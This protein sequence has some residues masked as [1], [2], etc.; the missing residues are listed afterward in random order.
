MIWSSSPD[1]GLGTLLALWPQI[2]SMYPSARLDIFYGWNIIDKLIQKNNSPYLRKLKEDILGNI[3]MLGGQEAGIYQRGRVPQKELADWQLNSHIWAYPTDF[4]ETFCITAIEMQ[5]AGVIP[6][7]SRLAALQE[8][9]ANPELLIEGWPLNRDYQR[10]WLKV[11]EDVVEGT[12]EHQI[13]LQ[14]S[15]RRFAEQFSWDASYNQWQD[16]IRNL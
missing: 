4:C 3:A 1:R 11:L 15:G 6:V 13:E 7:A 10:R 8:T 16:L 2:K 5:A 9:V 14:L 12:D